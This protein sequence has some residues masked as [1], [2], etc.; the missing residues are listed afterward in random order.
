MEAKH[1]YACPFGAFPDGI[2]KQRQ[3]KRVCGER[4]L[5]TIMGFMGITDFTTVSTEL[6]GV[7]VGRDLTESV[8]NAVGQ[9]KLEALKF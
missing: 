8:N 7:L 1:M 6:T 3:K 4:Y 9:A 2:V 5:R